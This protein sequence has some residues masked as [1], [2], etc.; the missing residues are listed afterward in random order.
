MMEVQ[1]QQLFTQDE[2][3]YAVP[4]AGAKCA[5]C[6]FFTASNDDAQCAIVASTPLPISPD[7]GCALHVSAEIQTGTADS[8]IDLPKRVAL[9]TGL[10]ERRTLGR[11]PAAETLRRQNN[12]AASH[13]FKAL[14][15]GLWFAAFTNNFRDKDGEILT[16]AAHKRYVAWAQQKGSELPE[17]WVWHTAGT[18]C[19]KAL[20]VDK[21]GHFVYAVGRFDDS[22]QGRA[23]EAFAQSVKG[24]EIT[25]SHGF[26]Y[27]DWARKDGGIID[28]YR[29]FEISIL[30]EGAEANPYTSFESIKE[31]QDMDDN[32][33]AFFKRI[34]GQ[35]AKNVIAQVENL[36]KAGKK[37]ADAG[38]AYKD[39]ADYTPKRKAAKNAIKAK[40]ARRK[41]IDVE[42]I[43]ELLDVEEPNLD[44]IIEFLEEVLDETPSE[45]DETEELMLDEV[46]AGDE[47]EKADEDYKGMYEDLVTALNALLTEFAPMQ[48]ALSTLA[49]DVKALKRVINDGLPAAPVGRKSV[50]AAPQ[51]DL[52]R[53]K[54]ALA[55][56]QK[57]ANSTDWGSLLPGLTKD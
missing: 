35:Q 39:Y 4:A 1:K 28:D 26:V 17:L 31:M 2:V 55:D 5:T 22:E 6:R 32:K 46:E 20:W 14:G 41:E 19:G 43:E 48:K 56:K 37:L 54:K 53:A 27:P 38:A 12:T 57:V 30:P 8:L 9:S 34:F 25:L 33:R 36:E 45:S 24:G 7:G 23:A 15:N 3:G 10:A 42:K 49:G 11:Y 44:A 51:I 16:E 18:R 40:A 29:T 47:E 21:A 50:G 13:T 52:E